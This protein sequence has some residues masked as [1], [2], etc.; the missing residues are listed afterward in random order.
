MK[1]MLHCLTI[2]AFGSVLAIPTLGSAMDHGSH[3]S[4]GGHKMKAETKGATPGK[5]AL[6]GTEIRTADVQGYHLTY[7]LIDMKEMMKDMPGK[8]TDMGKMKSHHLMVYVAGP[9]GKTMTEG[10]VGYLVT[11]PGKAEQK[12]M[13]MS[14]QDGYGA[15]VDLKTMG[16]YKVT[17]KA[18]VGGKTIVDEFS[19][20]VR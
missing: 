14:M 15:D 5:P 20:T 16:D 4:M 7:R 18:V 19:Y 12:T 6:K 9:D 2:L 10:K 8:D 17:T 1:K 11:G 3:G 13:A